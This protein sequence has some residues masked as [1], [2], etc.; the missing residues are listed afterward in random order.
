[1]KNIFYILAISLINISV[2]GQKPETVYSYALVQKSTTWY[3]EQI[4]AWKKVIKNES[5]NGLAWY[6]YYYATRNLLAT[7][8]S[9]KRSREIKAEERI[10]LVEEMGK[11]IPDAYE[12]HLCTWKEHLGEEKFQKHLDKVYELGENRIEHIDFTINDG[13]FARDFEKRNN[14]LIKKWKAGLVSPGMANYNRNVLSGLSENA[15]LLTVGDND[16]YPAWY[17]Q[18]V[19]FRPDVHI[20]NLNLLAMDDY[21]NT[22]FKELGVRPMEI[23][24][25]AE[26]LDDPNHI[27]NFHRKLLKALNENS[28][29][30]DVFV[31]LTVMGVK[32]LVEDEQD[33]LYLTGLAYLYDT[34]AVDERALLK[35]NFEHR[36]A[37]D[38]LQQSFYHDLSSE[39]VK[40]I[41]QNYILPMFKLYEHYDIS[42][43]ITKKAWLKQLMLNASKGTEMQFEVKNLFDK[44]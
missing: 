1:M 18:A 12:F 21:R 43:D 20:L 22:V 44:C 40:Q 23:N 28:N 31:G 10:K 11:S 16:T 29:G 17:V 6:N 39:L 26:S 42:G 35:R 41:N 34:E 30:F 24:W 33:Q 9:D 25:E 4:T 5:G 14:G 37:L 36:Y 19:G 7:D 8:T 13:E 2:Y 38:Y 3:K 15:I 27:K 32:D